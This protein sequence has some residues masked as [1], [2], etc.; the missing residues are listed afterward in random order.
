MLLL[1]Q[2]QCVNSRIYRVGFPV[3][4]TK[5]DLEVSHLEISSGIAGE[6]WCGYE[7]SVDEVVV[8]NSHS[9]T[10]STPN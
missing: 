6:V 2:I 10:I 5:V 3:L 8:I 4:K 9:I 1:F 7:N